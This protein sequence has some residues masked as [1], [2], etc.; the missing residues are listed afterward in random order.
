MTAP[1]PPVTDETLDGAVAGVDVLLMTGA[2]NKDIVMHDGGRIGDIPGVDNKS[3]QSTRD[4]EMHADCGI[5]DV[6]PVGADKS[7]TRGLNSDQPLVN[8]VILEGTT[9]ITAG[10]MTAGVSGVS[11]HMPVVSAT[12]TTSSAQVI[13]NA[14]ENTT[15]PAFVPPAVLHYLK[16]VSSSPKWLRMLVDYLAFEK[17]QPMTGVCPFIT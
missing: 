5:A 14:F 11:G 15:A 3:G 9:T 4:V 13:L 8:T 2:N 7:D 17:D 1:H 12:G 16:E 10:V 6:P